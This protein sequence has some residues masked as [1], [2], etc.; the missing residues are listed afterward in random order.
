MA[1]ANAFAGGDSAVDGL[2][3]EAMANA[4]AFDAHVNRNVAINPSVCG[5]TPTHMS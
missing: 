4:A 1:M 2:G 5:S 3:D